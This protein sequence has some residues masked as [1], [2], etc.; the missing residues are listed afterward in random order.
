MDIKEAYILG[1]NINEHWYYQAKS[2]AVQKLLSGI[3]YRY[4]L[5]VGAGSGFFAKELLRHPTAVAATC[6]DTSYTHEWQTTVANKPIHFMRTIAHTTA[7]L[8]LLMDVLEHVHNDLELLCTYT[9]KIPRGSHV[10]IT[11]PAF[12]FLWSGHDVFLEHQRRYTLTQI[13]GVVRKAGLKVE[14]SCYFFGAIFPI[15]AAVRLARRGH[16]HNKTTGSD[17]RAYSP[18]IN[19]VLS[20][21]CKLELPLMSYNR[22]CGLTALCLAYKPF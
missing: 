15:A 16:T 8:L 9:E 1:D 14:R 5:D 4:I 18:L 3:S 11:V 12:M 17:L 7:D 20:S 13:E 22:I 6:V 2:Q 19:T 10:L 21:V